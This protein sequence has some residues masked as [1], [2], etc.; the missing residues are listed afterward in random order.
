MYPENTINRATTLDSSG[1]M[2]TGTEECRVKDDYLALEI[3]Y[4][5]EAER[6]G[7]LDQAQE[8]SPHS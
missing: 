3:S 2:L 1:T 8:T 6:V 4:V 7:H 5:G